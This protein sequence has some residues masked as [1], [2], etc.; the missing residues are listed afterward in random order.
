MVVAHP[1]VDSYRSGC[2]S[3]SS[4]FTE[5]ATAAAAAAAAAAVASMCSGDVLQLSQGF[6]EVLGR[7][8]GG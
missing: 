8:G 1:G 4:S 5:T 2:E 3:R 7:G 6:L